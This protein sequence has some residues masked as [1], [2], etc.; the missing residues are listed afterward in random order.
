[1]ECPQLLGDKGCAGKW[2][3]T[4]LLR[5][6]WR[7]RPENLIGDNLGIPVQEPCRMPPNTLQSIP[8]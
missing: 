3:P 6:L 2:P 4:A 1:M 7:D 8:A 5:A